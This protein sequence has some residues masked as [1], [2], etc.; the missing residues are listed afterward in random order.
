MVVGVVDEAS[1]DEAEVLIIIA[2]CFK[3]ATGW[4]GD[5]R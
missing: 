1:R 2:I 3:S 4:S 5:C